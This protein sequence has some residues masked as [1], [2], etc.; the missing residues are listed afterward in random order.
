M[1]STILI[2]GSN[3]GI[4]FELT[5]QY[6]GEGWRVLACSRDLQR[7]Q[8]LGA[9]KE[10]YPDSLVLAALDV[11]NE[12]QIRALAN[13]W[14]SES[15]D[16][17]YNNAGMMGP[18]PEFGNLAAKGWEEV[19]LVN[20]IAPILIAQAFLEQVARSQRRIIA[21][22]SSALGSI[23]DN[24]TGKYYYYRSSKAAL[25][26]AMKC[27]SIDLR[28]R[29]ITCVALHPGW[30]QTRMG[31]PEAPLP[32]VESVKGIR[33]VLNGLRSA[34]NGKFFNYQGKELEW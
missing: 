10:Q 1:T 5:R 17:L 9:L 12:Q 23:G 16:I 4:G 34:D 21:S 25:N 2:T 6:L 15:I 14:Q 31:G 13:E 26:M 24:Q 3:R 29:G 28:D 19:L 11:S 18:Q 7:A 8:E 30:V 33:E 32:V 20:S 27:L 22:M